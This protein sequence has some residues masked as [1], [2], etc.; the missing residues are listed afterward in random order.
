MNNNDAR[1][2]MCD[3]A[4]FIIH[5]YGAAYHRADRRDAAWF[6]IKLSRQKS[7]GAFWINLVDMIYYIRKTI[8][9][10]KEKTV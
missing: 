9:G 2:T 3:R 5:H 8:T 1:H 7:L 10:L 6:D 4:F